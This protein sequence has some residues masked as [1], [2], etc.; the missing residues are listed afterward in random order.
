MQ[1]VHGTFASQ[2]RVYSHQSCAVVSSAYWT[3]AFWWASLL[4][5]LGRLLFLAF[6]RAVLSLPPL[7]LLLGCLPV[8]F[9][10]PWGRVVCW[11]AWSAPSRR[12]PGRA[13]SFS[14]VACCSWSSRWRSSSSWLAFFVFAFFVLV[15]FVFCGVCR[16]GPSCSWSRWT[17]PVLLA[18]YV[19]VSRHFS[20]LRGA[21]QVERFSACSF[22]I[23]ASSFLT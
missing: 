14:C 11:S 5:F 16:S 20:E 8:W 12:R 6:L 22:D 18:V 23:A 17:S 4:F 1:G 9:A 7:R 19:S 2:G 21:R 10:W 13:S 15:L 3:L